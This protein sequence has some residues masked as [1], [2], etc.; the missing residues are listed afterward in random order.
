MF[1]VCFWLTAWRIA[2][3]VYLLLIGASVFLCPYCFPWP[4]AEINT[5]I[6]LPSSCLTLGMVW[7]GLSDVL[8]LVFHFQT[9]Q[10]NFS[11]MRPSA[12]SLSQGHTM[13]EHSGQDSYPFLAGIFS[14]ICQLQCC[15]W[16]RHFNDNYPS[17]L[18][19]HCC[20]KTLVISG[21]SHYFHCFKILLGAFKASFFGKKKNFLHL[22]P[23]KNLWV[24]P[25][26]S[27]ERFYDLLQL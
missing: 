5:A 12:W 25:G 21:F 24:F 2:L 7:P 20:G 15:C 19:G 26:S 6:I 17:D 23:M 14:K 8:G 16:H 11:F 13:Q 1:L 10:L 3:N 9:R 18:Y 4:P 22:F 27:W